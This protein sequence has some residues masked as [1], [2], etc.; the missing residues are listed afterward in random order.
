MGGFTAYVTLWKTLGP[1]DLRV[2]R[3]CGLVSSSASLMATLFGFYFLLMI[4][5]YR[6]VYRHELI[7]SLLIFD[8]IK[9]LAMII[10]SSAAITDVSTGDSFTNALG[11]I[12]T[13]CIQG[14]DWIILFFA[15]HITL[16]VFKSKLKKISKTLK[17]KFNF[18]NLPK[19]PNISYF[20]ESNKFRVGKGLRAK[21]GGLFNY[22]GTVLVLS[23]VIPAIIASLGFVA[24]FQGSVYWSFLKINSA[25]WSFTWLFRY[26]VV[27]GIMTLYISIYIFV[28]IEYKKVSK[29]IQL[30]T[31]NNA[32]G[33]D[34][35]IKNNII[36]NSNNNTEDGLIKGTFG[37]S[38]WYKM[39]QWILMLVFPD[40]GIT[41]KLH[42]QGLTSSADL[43]N[44]EKLK[45]DSILFGSTETDSFV[46]SRRSSLLTIPLPVYKGT[47][48]NSNS[49]SDSAQAQMQM[50]MPTVNDQI[51]VTQQ[52]QSLINAEIMEKFQLRR[53]QILRQMNVIFIY[54]ASYVFLWI[55]PFVSHVYILKNY[56][57]I[58]PWLASTTAFFQ[59][60]N[61]VV[62]VTVF[63]IR[64]KP[65]QL[66]TP[67]N[68][69]DNYSWRRLLYFLPGFR[70]YAFYSD[71]HSEESSM[72][73]PNYQDKSIDSMD[74]FCSNDKCSISSTWKKIKEKRFSQ[75]TALSSRTL[76]DKRLT[77]SNNQTKNNSIPISSISITNNNN[78]NKSGSTGTACTNN[79]N[80]NSQNPFDT[81]E[82]KDYDEINDTFNEQDITPATLFEADT[83]TSQELDL[84]A[85]LNTGQPA[86]DHH[87]S[88]RRKS[89][90][91]GTRRHNSKQQTISSASLRRNSSGVNITPTTFTPKLG[92]KEDVSWN[93]NVFEKKQQT[94]NEMDLLDFLNSEAPR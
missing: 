86:S 8:F 22:R 63:L 56:K 68:G 31:T 20:N 55:F 19:L 42:G 41:A 79:S 78:S 88:N 91:V 62:D 12:T 54:P 6:R 26:I 64:E 21:E 48:L 36:N 52:I 23:T 32:D 60:F 14:S 81:D 70:S 2:E 34:D 27:L 87:N 75:D 49:N 83:N 71:Y 51:Q 40:V 65:W 25:L 28:M 53:A 80:K 3:I 13:F 90:S 50:Q 35:N 7:L 92:D 93:L 77:S 4:N 43:K 89:K 1:N 66:R 82:V 57:S 59:G 69:E 74:K 46:D 94:H 61:G 85:F 73:I 16:L 45:N 58:S 33:G 67:D 17:L 5:P 9:S 37:D 30:H 15:I 44:I 24:G 38:L 18:L 39:S 76:I 72:D 29:K 10:Y 11:W 47:N 84:M